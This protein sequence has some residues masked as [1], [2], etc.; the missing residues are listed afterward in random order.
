MGASVR[1]SADAE[2]LAEALKRVAGGDRAAFEEVY[3]RTAA[4]LFGVCL[5]IL[6]I[7]AEAEDVL[8]DVYCAVWRNAAL[9]DRQRG[10]AMTWLMTIARNRSVDQVRRSKW[11][12]LAPIE[13]ADRVA[14]PQ[15]MACDMISAD[16]EHRRMRQC[17]DL[18]DERDATA[19]RMAFFEGSTYA[20]LAAAMGIPVGTMKS[21]MRRALLQIRGRMV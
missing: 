7:R 9:F 6:P 13:S 4:K 12:M 19:I 16:E 5:Q 14:D 8:Q 3:R 2:A 15:P 1:N 17:L 10:S 20:D 18:L 11:G 21:R